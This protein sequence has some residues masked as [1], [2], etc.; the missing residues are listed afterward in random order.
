M[1]AINHSHLVLRHFGHLNMITTAHYIKF[2]YT[3]LSYVCKLHIHD[4]IL[5]LNP[6]VICSKSIAWTRDQVQTTSNNIYFH[7]RGLD[8]KTNGQKFTFS[9]LP[10]KFGAQV[11]MGLAPNSHRLATRGKPSTWIPRGGLVEQT[12]SER[13]AS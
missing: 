9:K 5:T 4:I 8:S 3:T 12:C 11:A 6:P 10:P 13:N 1:T 7:I 2:K